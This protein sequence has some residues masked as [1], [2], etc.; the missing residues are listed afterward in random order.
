MRKLIKAVVTCL[1]E[2]GYSGT[3]TPLIAKRAG[4]TRG[5]LQHHF[6]SKDDLLLAA[7][8]HLT[9]LLH[10]RLLRMKKFRGSLKV[11]CRH[12]VEILW[13]VFG[14][15]EYAAILELMV[16]TR[17]DPQL[18]G[19]II[20]IRANSMRQ[21]DL[22]WA[23]VFS[24]LQLP[25]ARLRDARYLVWMSLAGLSIQ[26]MFPLRRGFVADELRLIS[27]ALQC[28]FES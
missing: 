11:R 16:G 8:V 25:R 7:H 23:R 26:A 19:A 9:H 2:H 22:I 24:D 15:S 6:V 20:D 28:I 4:V 18:H 10:E 3:T 5:A 13:E 1:N 14:S 21:E 12:I 17:G 27:E